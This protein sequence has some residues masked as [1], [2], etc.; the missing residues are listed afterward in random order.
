MDYPSILKVVKT[1]N[2]K[3]SHKE[4]QKKASEL[5]KKFLAAEE[6]L[7]DSDALPKETKIPDKP[8]AD[9]PELPKDIPGNMIALGA[10]KD[11]EQ[12]IRNIGI[13]KSNICLFGNKL[14]PD[15]QLVKHGRIGINTEVSFEDPAGN[16]IPVDGYFLIWI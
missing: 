13:N 6:E 3:M 7:A 11:V 5:H 4:A 8:N 15:G 1:Q 12:Q 9:K 14:M 16:K 10:L 2:P